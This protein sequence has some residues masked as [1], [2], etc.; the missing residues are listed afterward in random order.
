[1]FLLLDRFP[2]AHRAFEKIPRGK[3]DSSVHL[4][5]MRAA[6]L[7]G[8]ASA[9]RREIDWFSG[10]PEEYSSL[11]QQALNHAALGQIHLAEDLAGQSVRSAEQRKLASAAARTEADTALFEDAAGRCDAAHVHAVNG[12]DGTPLPVDV[13]PAALALAFCGYDTEAQKIAERTSQRWPLNTIWNTVYLP[14]IRAAIAEKKNEPEKALELLRSPACCDR[15][16]TEPVYLRGLAFLALHRGAEA[17]TE[18]RK[19]LDHKGANWS[20]WYSLSYLGLSRAE[21]SQKAY[22]DFL[23]VWKDADA[24]LPALK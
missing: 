12:A 24:G 7:E 5:M 4:Y 18:F 16:Y 3:A 11:D 9:E 1:M 2:D 10:K 21:N 22:A 14:T 6:E 15:R 19:I 13:Y 20:I 23:T 17:A 8:D